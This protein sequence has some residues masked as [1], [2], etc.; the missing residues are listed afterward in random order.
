MRVAV[1]SDALGALDTAAAG[2]AIAEGWSRDGAEVALCP[3]GEAAEQFR[4]AVS[5]YAWTDVVAVGL[6]GPVPEPAVRPTQSTLELGELVA[7]A[8]HTTATTVCVDLGAVAALDGGAG[9][10]SAL[11]A[12]ADG[13]L[14]AGLD[15]L[16]ALTRVDISAARTAVAG[17]T[18][19]G[20]V[21][22]GEADRVLLG[23]RGAVS[24]IGHEAGM[25]RPELLDH[26]IAMEHW[27]RLADPAAASVPGAG[28]AGGSGFA[29]TALGGS[30]ATGSRWLA[31]RLGLPATLR[32]ADVVVTCCARFDVEA[33]RAGVVRTVAELAAT[34]SRPCVVLTQEVL[35]GAREMRALGVEAAYAA[36][37]GESPEAQAARVARTWRW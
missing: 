17:R 23:L 8:T 19:V 6:P 11:G 21:P 3:V 10:L 22:D 13:P 33:C 12:T 24:L 35:V 14:D 29:V 34:A 37:P 36:Q 27:S 20:I 5:S 15:E 2:R 26:E 32:Q 28:A 1:V 25:A 9:L 18:I 7:A 30:I 31:G 4:T 16:R